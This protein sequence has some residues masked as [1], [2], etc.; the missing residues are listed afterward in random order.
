MT[1]TLAFAFNDRTS[2][3]LSFSDR[4]NGKDSLRATG[5]PWTKIIGSQA[6]AATL[7]VGFTYALDAHTTIVTL[8]GMGMT[9][10]APDFTLTFKIPY[11]F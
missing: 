6:N 7:N 10:D 4:I 8:L 1:S 11:M 2:L 5:G 3:S 9:P